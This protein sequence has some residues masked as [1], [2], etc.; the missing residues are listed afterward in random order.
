MYFH[1]DTE[2][3][4]DRSLTT[5]RD[6]AHQMIGESDQD[7]TSL[8]TC[9]SRLDLQKPIFETIKKFYD[10]K[11]PE[12]FAKRLGRAP[13]LNLTFTTIRR[14]LP[15][16]SG[17]RV[18]WHLDLNFVGDS[19]P[20]LVAWVPLED[21]GVVRPGLEIYMPSGRTTD[22][23]SLLEAWKARARAGGAMSFTSEEIAEILDSTNYRVVTLRMPAGGAAVFDQYVLHRTQVLQQA[24]ETRHSFE[25]RMV[26]LDT[27]SVFDQRRTAVYC[28]PDDTAKGGI[29]FW[30][31]REDGELRPMHFDES[32]G[33][34][35]PG[36]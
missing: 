20:F 30:I 25:F 13:T 34:F 31:R 18:D 32:G 36:L 4:T 15:D 2:I 16:S 28:R 27:L 10:S 23:G 24:A 12:V 9:I 35:R 33:V 26:D 21:V 17:S 3:F 22:F 11:L 1:S 6:C 8:G 5:I 19:A 7:K 14:H 29:G